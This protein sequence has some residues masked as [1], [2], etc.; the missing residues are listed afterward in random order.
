M[1]SKGLLEGITT[2]NPEHLSVLNSHTSKL[3][4]ISS[5]LSDLPKQA[6]TELWR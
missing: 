1:I 5:I 6:Q 4:E 2:G 3:D